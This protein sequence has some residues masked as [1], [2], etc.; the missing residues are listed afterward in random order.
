MLN[1]EVL[2]IENLSVCYGQFEHGGNLSIKNLDLSVQRGEIVGVVGESGSGKTT[3]AHAIMGMLRE[4]GVYESGSVNFEGA[5]LID[6]D[7]RSLQKIRGKELAMIVANPRSELNPLL[8]VGQQLS[9]VAAEHLGISKRE[10][11]EIALKMLKAVSIPDPNARMRAYPHQLSGGMAQRVVIAMAL[12]NSP[13]FVISDDA[14]SGLDVTVQTQVLDLLRKL[15][16]EQNMSMLYITRDIGVA[17]HFCDRIAVVYKGEVVEIAETKSL[18]NDPHHP[19]T[20]MLMAAFSQSRPLRQ[21]W[22]MEETDQIEIRSDGCSFAPRC[23]NAKKR[24]VSEHPKLEEV[25]P[26]RFARCHFPVRR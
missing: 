7:E 8:T 10:A 3:L 14:T 1:E 23:V 17:A 4:P 6:L 25:S 22:F 21:R 9:Q 5:N 20:N 13:K 2:R 11:K 19:Y 16:R 12:I 26:E 24:C 18:F 15:T